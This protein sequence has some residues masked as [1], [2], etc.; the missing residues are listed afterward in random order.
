MQFKKRF[1]LVERQE[2]VDKAHDCLRTKQGLRGSQYLLDSRNLSKETVKTFKLGY[3]PLHVNHQLK[4]R[5]ILPIY[6]P[7]KNLIAV[8]S[9]AVGKSDFLPVYWH[10]QYEK[11][12]Y[13]YGIDNASSAMRK[14]GF[15]VVVEGQ[16]DQLSLFNSGIKNVVALCGNKMS[17]VQLSIMYRYCDEI[18]LLLDT[19]EN[20]A[21]QKGAEKVM[22]KA[23]FKHGERSLGSFPP[24]LYAEQPILTQR[25]IAS[26]SF[27]ENIDPDEFV[28]KYG[29]DKL[30][31]K[32]KEKVY[33]LRKH[34]C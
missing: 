20:Q 33:A 9:R 4:G 24:P 31:E 8:S 34:D 10:E 28:Q 11:S 18:V 16:F 21:G 19:D 15:V 25:K 27:E 5:I 30:K 2:I 7:S 26:L 23:T 14:F 1:N 3:I 12:F 29:I 13:L 17:E 6:D 22:Q 32:I